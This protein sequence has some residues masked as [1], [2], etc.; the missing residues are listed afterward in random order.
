MNHFFNVK[1]YSTK[2]G[3]SL[4]YSKSASIRSADWIR[5]YWYTA[6][7]G[8]VEN[9]VVV[10]MGFEMVFNLVLVWRE[11]KKGELKGSVALNS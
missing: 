10:V 1:H 6:F 5:S 11:Q 2:D 7:Y 3:R 8:I 4:V 9:S